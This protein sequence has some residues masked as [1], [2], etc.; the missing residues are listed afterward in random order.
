MRIEEISLDTIKPYERNARK[1]ANAVNGVAES[2]KQFGFQQPIVVDKNNV[3]VAGH[4][5]YKAAQQL[6][7]N[8]VPCVRADD[9]TPEQVKAYRILDNKLNE[10]ASW[11]FQML[12]EELSSFDFNFEAFN[13]SLP[14][15]DI[16]TFFNEHETDGNKVLE[17]PKQSQSSITEQGIRNT[18]NDVPVTLQHTESEINEYKEIQ[19]DYDETLKK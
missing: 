12:G 3:I 10:L 2:I 17:N 4:T 19:Q 8:T 16:S 11:D 1:N 5:R 18:S 6:G 15:Y 9:L 7:M 13:V 14:A